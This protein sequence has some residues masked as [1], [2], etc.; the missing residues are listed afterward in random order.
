MKSKKY[1]S[2]VQGFRKGIYDNWNKAKPQIEGYRY[3]IY[4]SFKT[5]EEAEAWFNSGYKDDKQYLQYQS[6]NI[7]IK[8][9]EKDVKEDYVKA[10]TKSY[11]RDNLN[12]VKSNSRLHESS[13][14][15]SNAINI[16]TDGGSRNTGNIKG[17]HVNSDDLAGWAYEI[18]YDDKVIKDSGTKLGATNNEME[19]RALIQ[20][21]LKLIELKLTTKEIVANLDSMYVIN[22]ATKWIKKWKTTDWKRK[23]KYP[24][25]NLELLKELDS[26]L[27]E[28]D[29]IRFNWVKGHADN[30][31]NVDVDN[32]LNV[33]MNKES[34]T[35]I[36]KSSS[37][38]KA[39]KKQIN[40]L[41]KLSNE[42]LPDELNIKEASKLIS[43]YLDK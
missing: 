9:Y 22:C 20:C 14:T 8:E 35:S 29:N 36:N 23:G 43:F 37:I 32:A 15:N 5:K 3:P 31:G 34:G 39:T 18:K 16:W 28:F 13:F 40:Y 24:I 4:K 17:G 19:L 27:E 41:K 26:D 10:R 30:Q 1:Y 25:K 33:A 11:S 21:L 6:Q 2:V 7:D 42:P 38:P 12:R